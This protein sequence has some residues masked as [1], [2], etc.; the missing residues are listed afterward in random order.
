ML[1]MFLLGLTKATGEVGRSHRS[2]TFLTFDWECCLLLG[3]QAVDEFCQTSKEKSFLW[4]TYLPFSIFSCS[5]I[6]TWR[7]Q[8]LVQQVVVCFVLF[9]IDFSCISNTFF[10]PSIS[11]FRHVTHSVIKIRDFSSADTINSTNL[12]GWHN[13][14]VLAFIDNC[15]ML[16]ADNS[17]IFLI[18]VFHKHQIKYYVWQ[19]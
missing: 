3:F 5:T 7:L 16:V 4:I 13:M 1:H 12:I 17:W 6:C 8:L 10:N 2:H 14:S 9:I 18:I 11:G 15:I 19:Y